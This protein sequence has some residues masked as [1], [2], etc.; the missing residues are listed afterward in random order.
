MSTKL[1]IAVHYGERQAGMCC[2]KVSSVLQ[3]MEHELLAATLSATQLQQETTR[4]QGLVQES[5][6]RLQTFRYYTCLTPSALIEPSHSLLGSYIAL[7]SRALLQET[8]GRGPQRGGRSS[9]GARRVLAGA[10]RP[11]SLMRLARINL[12]NQLSDNSVQ[13]SPAMPAVS[14]CSKRIKSSN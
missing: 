7:Q 1:S 13:K 6:D 14:V 3:R 11:G 5:N 2:L 4:L 9:A 10:K 12:L 8:N